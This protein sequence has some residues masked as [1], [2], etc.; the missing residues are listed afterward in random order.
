MDKHLIS[1]IQLVWLDPEH[2]MALGY[3][4]FPEA[5]EGHLL[6]FQYPIYH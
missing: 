5:P 6:L 3:L 4:I 1:Q 2:D